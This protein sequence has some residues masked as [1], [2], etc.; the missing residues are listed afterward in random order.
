MEDCDHKPMIYCWLVSR[1]GEADTGVKR[2]ES[3]ISPSILPW[4]TTTTLKQRSHLYSTNQLGISGAPD[5][6]SV[7]FQ[8][9]KKEKNG[10]KCI[11]I[12]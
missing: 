7:L 1:S 9:R 3:I 2:T 12:K 10:I 8:N 6:S 5:F 4:T 11:S